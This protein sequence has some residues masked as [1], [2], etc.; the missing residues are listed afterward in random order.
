MINQIITETNV[1]IRNFLNICGLLGAPGSSPSIGIFL[2]ELLILIGSDK[3][4]TSHQI[5]R[6][7]IIEPVMPNFK[8]LQARLVFH[9]SF[10]DGERL[11]A[12]HA[13]QSLAFQFL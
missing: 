8:L 9:C 2:F 4:K 7:I 5:R 12:F 11:Q 6:K 1:V 13:R 10:L 3:K